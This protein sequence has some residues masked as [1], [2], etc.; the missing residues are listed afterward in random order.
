M[1]VFDS[2]TIRRWHAP[3]RDRFYR[4]SGPKRARDRD[5][6]A[7]PYARHRPQRPDSPSRGLGPQ[8]ARLPDPENPQGALRSDEHRVRPGDAERDRAR[9]QVER[10]LAAPPPHQD[11]GRGDRAFADDEGREIAFADEPAA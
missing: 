11:E 10:R 3:L 5:D 8:A 6:R 7:L 9:V 1:Q 2:P 4:P